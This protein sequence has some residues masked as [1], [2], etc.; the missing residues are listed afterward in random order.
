MI[1]GSWWV[2]S[3]SAYKIASPDPE[4]NPAGCGAAIR[5]A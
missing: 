5:E 3:L 2:F 4:T 1:G